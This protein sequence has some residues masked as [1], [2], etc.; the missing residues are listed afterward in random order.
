MVHKCWYEHRL[1]HRHPPATYAPHLDTSNSKKSEKRP[2]SNDCI[3]RQVS[4]IE[5]GI[6]HEL[7]EIVHH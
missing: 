7:I 5:P 1:G 6:V 3:R 2:C 4:L